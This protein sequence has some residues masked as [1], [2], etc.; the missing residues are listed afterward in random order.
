M[1]GANA[2]GASALRNG[3]VHRFPRALHLALQEFDL[4][5]MFGIERQR[6]VVAIRLVGAEAAVG[7]LFA[8]RLQSG[9][10]PQL[11]KIPVE[12]PQVPDRLKNF[13]RGDGSFV[14]DRPA[15]RPGVTSKLGALRFL[16]PRDHAVHMNVQRSLEETV[17]AAVV[18]LER[19]AS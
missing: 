19:S 3:A 10:E 1:R 6:R 8:P 13:A 11:L 4:D 2:S 14:V 9:R 15:G 16:R 7:G 12:V 18:I 5:E 17:V